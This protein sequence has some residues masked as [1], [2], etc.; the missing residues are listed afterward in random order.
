M[1]QTY[2]RRSFS[3]L[4]FTKAPY[5]RNKTLSGIE[6]DVQMKV[7]S[8]ED[9]RHQVENRTWTM[10]NKATGAL[11]SPWHDIENE[12]TFNDDCCVTGVIEMSA[13]TQ[14]KL[15]CIKDV[16]HNPIMQDIRINKNTKQYELRKFS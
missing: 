11:M 2:S 7:Q 8:K 1:L 13:R 16:A 15:E 10:V 4:V 5:I 14:N 12:S 9:N 3:R 6:F